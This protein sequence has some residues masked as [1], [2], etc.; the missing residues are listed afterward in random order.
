MWNYQESDWQ[1]LVDTFLKKG[2]SVDLHRHLYGE[3]QI[4]AFSRGV[5]GSLCQS[6]STSKTP[7]LSIQ[8]YSQLKNAELNDWITRPDVGLR[9]HEPKDLLK[10][11]SLHGESQ[12]SY[13]FS[14]PY[15]QSMTSETAEL[16]SELL[17][18][19]S[20]AIHMGWNP[21]AYGLTRGQILKRPFKEWEKVLAAD[22]LHEDECRWFHLSSAPYHWAGADPR[23]ELAVMLAL[24]WSIIEE[25]SYLGVPFSEAKKKINF[26]L[27]LGTDVLISSSKVAAMK[28]LWQRLCEAV[29]SEGEDLNSNVYAMPSLRHFSARDPWNNIMRLT[30]MSFSALVGGAQGVKPL[31]IDIL[32]DE[33][34]AQSIRVSMN[35][36]LLLQE[37]G[38]VILNKAPL[39][40][41]DLFTRTV[42]S[43]CEDAWSYFQQIQNKKGIFEAIRSGW[44]QTELKSEA[45]KSRE[46]Y[47]SL[48]EMIIGTSQHISK[49]KVPM[50][51]HQMKKLQDVVEPDLYAKE[52]KDYMNVEPVIVESLTYGWEYL[53]LL[54]DQWREEKKKPLSV[55][56]IRY[57]GKTYEKKISWVTRIMS[58]VGVEV[59]WLNLDDI[60]NQE[61][62]TPASLL[63][64]TNTEDE[65]K[66]LATLAMKG[67]KATWYVGKRDSLSGFAG[68]I[69]DGANIFQVLQ[70]I[71]QQLRG[72][73]GN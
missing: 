60:A 63:L 18:E 55:I 25:L 72:E 3:K 24:A 34:T 31:P 42:D 66:A 14:Q 13:M 2:K 44:L 40:G 70:E 64:A 54:S 71:H 23:M 49:P 38:G 62:V 59:R 5:A 32:R 4:S 6:V 73:Y 10:E 12:R 46:S 69:Y 53:Q 67:V 51:H 21:L 1:S 65:Q 68:C 19:H 50:Q 33:Q 29:E 7:F 43:I 61:V 8:N 22:C 52:E 36:P 16:F 28:L 20:C 26:S 56:G 35:I 41:S 30:L 9:F 37:E 39:N 15:V 11:E 58:L 48:R 47:E 17:K 57:P 27:S 45:A